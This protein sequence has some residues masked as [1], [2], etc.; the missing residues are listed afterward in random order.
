[1]KH[2]S[3]TRA[4]V[5]RSLRHGLAMLL[6][7]GTAVAGDA[8][9]T[10]YRIVPLPL[11]ADMV[12]TSDYT[13]DANATGDVV[14]NVYDLDRG[15]QSAVE[16]S[17][18]DYAM[19]ILPDEGTVYTFAMRI[20]D[21][22]D[23][24][25]LAY[26]PDSPYADVVWK[27]DGPFVRIAETTPRG[28]GTNSSPFDVNSHGVIVGHTSV[29]NRA[30]PKWAIWPNPDKLVVVG[31]TGG[32]NDAARAISDSGAVVGGATTANRN[33]AHAFS[34][35]R[36]DGLRDLGDLPGGIDSSVANDVNNSGQAVG[37]GSTETGS[38]AVLWDA[39]GTMHD[40]GNLP[41]A[42]GDLGYYG[43]RLNNM[44]E[45]IGSTSTGLFWI[46]TAGTGM[47]PIDSLIDPNDPLYGTG[48][49]R[50]WSLN[51][52]GVMAASL[53]MGGGFST[54]VMLIP[55]P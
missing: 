45:V 49:L 53:N 14:G 16:W 12:F 36:A 30:V 17:A 48:S 37:V 15:R 20:G 24:L 9:A 8:L 7:A 51:D 50:L 27:S 32:R 33:I 54:P 43:D 47:V 23:I 1:M 44:G 52:A 18:P 31:A 39:D 25:G 46:W 13:L 42:A 28:A 38:R 19:R 35:T 2:Q 34:L 11:P 26:F 55:Q 4:A 5:T 6:L 3:R 10:T 21:G 41:G 29:G 40:L 22:G